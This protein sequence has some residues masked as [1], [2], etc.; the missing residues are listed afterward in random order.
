MFFLGYPDIFDSDLKNLF[1]I[2][3][4][5]KK[6][7]LITNYFQEKLQHRLKKLIFLQKH[8]NLY[9]FLTNVLKNTNLNRVRSLQEKF[10]DDLINGF[11]IYK[12]IKGANSAKDLCLCLLGNPN[13]TG[14]DLFLK[15]PKDK[16]NKDIYLQAQKLFSLRESIF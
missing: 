15:T 4:L 8:G 13:R 16:Y 6:R 2:L 9:D 10:L 14:Y 12:K 5:K 11:N 1:K 3:H 7:I